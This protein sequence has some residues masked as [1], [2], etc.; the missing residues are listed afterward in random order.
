MTEAKTGL[1]PMGKAAVLMAGV[2]SGAGNST[3]SAILPSIE[4]EYGMFSGGIS[5]T[6]AFTIFGLGMLF[7]SVGG[8]WL[9]DRM[10]RRA[11]MVGSGLLF[12]IAGC[13]VMLADSLLHVVIARFFTGLSSGAA[14][15][16]AYAVIGD[17]FDDKGRNQWTGLVTAF[18]A[19][20][21]IGLAIFAASLADVGWRLSFS[22]YAV[23]F[24]AAIAAFFGIAAFRRV[25]DRVKGAPLALLVA[26]VLLLLGLGVGAIT[27]GTAAYMPYRLMDIG[28][29]TNTA[30]ALYAIPAGLMVVVVSMAYGFIRRFVSLE[31]AFILGGV[32]AAAGMAGMALLESPPVVS[33]MLGVAGAGMGLIVP[34][35]MI[36]AIGVSN[37]E[38]RGAAIGIA[39]GA[40]FG[41][42]F[43]IQL[44][45]DP[46][47][48][49]SGVST[50][51]LVIA[52]MA[53][54]L[55]L[56]FPLRSMMGG[57][58]TAPPPA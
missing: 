48:A 51:L 54:L 57:A 8:G 42:P 3:L 33:A 15:V 14:M 46:V 40:M 31:L 36:Y 7:G 13:S 55:A 18:A 39:R 38:T 30:R 6:T 45:L 17:S 12:A 20:M 9:S 2:L 41:G 43:L 11:V 35:L 52:G 50:V 21:G 22:I 44:A 19:L 16:A 58:K 28:V 34:S 56:F 26:A 47:R 1:G 49:S 25:A 37:N 29:V 5:V 23:G 10:G 27:T 4:A 53:A 32:L 24:L